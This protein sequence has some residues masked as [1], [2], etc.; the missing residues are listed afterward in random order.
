MKTQQKDSV[1]S[2]HNTTDT[3]NGQATQLMHNLEVLSSTFRDLA[4]CNHVY[5]YELH[6]IADS[7]YKL[8]NNIKGQ[9]AENAMLRNYPNAI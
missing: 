9:H 4:V 2:P 3:T 8:R 6:Q 5:Q 1:G 7:I